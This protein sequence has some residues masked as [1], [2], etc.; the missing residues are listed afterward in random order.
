MRAMTMSWL[1]GWGYRKSHVIDPATGAGT[2]YPV[3]IRVAKNERLDAIGTLQLTQASAVIPTGS[4]GQW[5]EH[6]REIG[7]VLYEPTDTG[8]EYKTWFTG[9]TTAEDYPN[10]R[11]GYSYSSNGINWTTAQVT[12][13]NMP[14]NKN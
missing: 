6:I 1:S 7:N 13:S 8:K 10:L 3:E 5:N 2:N 14:A 4:A 12:L 9:W 11:I